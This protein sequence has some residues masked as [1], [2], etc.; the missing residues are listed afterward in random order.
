MNKAKKALLAGGE[1]QEK[2]KVSFWVVLP[3]IFNELEM[4]DGADVSSF[5]KWKDFPKKLIYPTEDSI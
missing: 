3:S 2:K 5:F 4:P 1:E